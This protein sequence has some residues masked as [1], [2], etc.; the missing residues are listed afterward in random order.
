MFTYIYVNTCMFATVFMMCLCVCVSECVNCVHV[1][2]PVFTC[3]CIF[4]DVCLYV[5]GVRL[6]DNEQEEE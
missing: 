2:F 5:L 4:I 1:C 6:E 3:T